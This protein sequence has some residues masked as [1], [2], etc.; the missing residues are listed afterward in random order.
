MITSITALTTGLAAILVIVSVSTFKTAV[1]NTPW[2]SSNSS[3][4]IFK[5][6]LSC[7]FLFHFSFSTV[8]W[9][10]TWKEVE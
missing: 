2:L 9:Y 4:Y 8:F 7:F 3:Y 10:V 6:Q 5:F 1:L